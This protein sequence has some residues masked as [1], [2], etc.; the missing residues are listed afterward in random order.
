MFAYVCSIVMIYSTYML[1]LCDASVTALACVVMCARLWHASSISVLF[2]AI[3]V[4]LTHK[5]Q[6]SGGDA[7]A[8][9]L[10]NYH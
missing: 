1:G 7:R 9:S 4:L 6:A 8:N 3:L 5:T 10:V 2:F